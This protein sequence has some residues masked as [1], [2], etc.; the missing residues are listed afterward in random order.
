LAY[1][2]VLTMLD[3]VRNNEYIAHRDVFARMAQRTAS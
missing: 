1:W 2:S 3:S